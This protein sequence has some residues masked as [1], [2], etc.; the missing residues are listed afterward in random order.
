MVCQWFVL[1]SSQ[2]TRLRSSVA[3]ATSEVTLLVTAQEH[4]R[5]N[6]PNVVDLMTMMAL[7]VVLER[8]CFFTSR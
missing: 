5:A 8:F 2:L 4:V 7:V 6:N 3:V 1:P